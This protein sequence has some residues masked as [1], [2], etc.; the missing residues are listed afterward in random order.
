M[1]CECKVH[2]STS[3]KEGSLLEDSWSFGLFG[4]CWFSVSA[5]K[6]IIFHCVIM[7]TVNIHIER[8]SCLIPFSRLTLPTTFS[9][10]MMYTVLHLYALVCSQREEAHCFQ[11]V[12]CLILLEC[13]S[14]TFFFFSLLSCFTCSLFEFLLNTAVLYFPHLRCGR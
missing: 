9:L 5:T 7:V 11:I 1:F 14:N 2:V 13:T 10:P 6:Q 4:L 8:K 12:R 3:N